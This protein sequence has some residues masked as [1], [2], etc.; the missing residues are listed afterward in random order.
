M[1]IVLLALLAC[2]TEDTG[3]E[4]ELIEDNETLGDSFC[5]NLD[6]SSCFLPFPSDVYLNEVDGVRSVQIPAEALPTTNQGDP[7]DITTSFARVDGFGAASPVVFRLNDAVLDTVPF[8][9]ASSLDADYPTVLLRADTGE[10]LAHWVEHDYLSTDANPP[11]LVIRPIAPLP[12]GTR[13]IVGVHGVKDSAGSVIAPSEGFQP[14]RDAT[15]STWVGV[16]ERRAHYEANIFPA[17]ESAGVERAALQLAWDF[18]VATEENATTPLVELRDAMFELI[19]EGP[20]F[21]VVSIV[22]DPHPS[23]AYTTTAIAKIPS[24]LLPPEE[25]GLRRLRRDAD[26]ELQAEGFE[27]IEFTF[28]VPHSVAGGMNA[29][30]MQYGHGFLGSKGEANNSWLR[31]MA[32]HFGF[33]VI[34]CDMQGMNDND[35]STWMNLIGNGGGQLADASEQAFQGVVNQ[36]VLQRLVSSGGL[37]DSDMLSGEVWYYG[38]SQGGSVGTVVT[39]LSQDI[40][41]SVLGVPGSGYPFL[42]HRSVVFS[43][44]AGVISLVFGT[45]EANA[46]FLSLLGTGWD[47]FDPL[48]FAPH[49]GGTLPNTPAKQVLLHVAKEDAQVMNEASFILGRASGAKLLTPAVRPVFGLDEAPYP[50]TGDVSLV[51]VDFSIPDDPTPL[52]PPAADTDTH[53]WLRRWFP[54]QEQMVHFLATGEVIDVCE[55]QPCVTAPLE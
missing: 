2:G 40:E 33:A 37:D 10:R 31:D 50:Y 6:D 13:I 9:A 45:S 19:P 53:G 7:I 18:T 29:P 26:G 3:S 44:Y 51:E 15:S 34:A 41:R 36:L 28:Q 17:L 20:D 4:N 43:G 14:L 25:T 1:R 47:A 49:F 46:W 22:P 21:E 23:I 48:T 30:V 42:L 32:D 16:G 39:A 12:R 52:T 55:G 27:E 54:A 35:L 5:E 38:N 11:Y 24:F 8:D